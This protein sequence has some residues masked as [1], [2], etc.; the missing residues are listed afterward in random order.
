MK[1][2][3]R[4]AKAELAILF[5][6]P[7]AWLILVIFVFQV[8]MS[9]CGLFENEVR[10]Q[11]LGYYLYETTRNLFSGSS[12]VFTSV[13]HYLY[14]YLPLLTM[15]LMSREMSSGSIK[16]LYSSPVTNTQIILGKYLSMMIYG[17]ILLS[18]LL[19]FILFG[20][21]VVKDFN[22][23]VPLSGFLGVYLLLCAYAAI[24]LFMSGLTSYQVIAAVGTL[25]VLAVLN[26]VGT[27]G[28]SV[29]LI[30]DIT[31]WLSISGRS[32]SL[33]DGLICSEDVLYFGIVVLLFLS[34]SI[35]RLQSERE[36]R[37]KILMASRYGG[38]IFCALLLGYVSSRPACMFYYDVTTAKSNTLTVQ[39]QEVMEKMEGGLKIVSYVNLLDV[40]CWRGLPANRNMDLEQFKQYV[41]FKPEIEME[42][43]YYYDK[44]N[45]PELD[46]RYPELS[47]RDRASRQAEIMRLDFEKFLSP[48]QVRE[49]VDLQPE[50]NRFVRV[51]ER[52]NGRK[53]FL[54]LYN[55]NRKDPLET[56]ITTALKRLVTDVPQVAFLS[57]HGERDIFRKGERDYSLMSTDVNSRS[58]LV[59][60]GFDVFELSLA[61][62]DVPAEV[63]ILVIAELREELSVPEAEKITRYIERGGNLIVLGEPERQ[64][65]MNPLIKQLGVEFMPGVLVQTHEGLAPDLIVA[66]VT[67]AAAKFSSAYAGLLA[68]QYHVVMPGA[69]GLDFDTTAGFEVTPIFSIGEDGAWS[70][71]E[72]TVFTD[73]QPVLNPAAGE[74][75]GDIPT[76]LALSRKLGEKEQRIMIIGD[77]DCWSN[78]E[79]TAGRESVRQYN[80]SLIRES[81]H[82]LSEG[83]F[84]MGLSRPGSPDNVVYFQL[85]RV[86]WVQ[87]VFMGLIPLLILLAGITL[88]VKRR[89]K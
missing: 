4:I 15:G 43:V 52:E 67:L 37:S 44:T 18:V 29:D 20:L 66:G 26:I 62:G 58:A 19:L 9:F 79:L 69:V 11:T 75:E 49:R 53:T 82:W 85:G 89:R 81:F 54:R 74:K 8:G 73:N 60:T 40:E 88:W 61:E 64:G 21:M 68:G 10:E 41:R 87:V 86:I 46:S 23:Q 32:N 65:A 55:D 12:G 27:I 83:E 57:G 59:N 14:L 72:M 63:D 45:S 56:E 48:E 77:A 3:F 71:L 17:F 39:S 28:Q 80:Y 22:W 36:K 24:G 5:Y 70:E 33:V 34:L 76:A 16:L 38:V 1:T 42:Y 13:S 78:R 6:S 25:V 51:L 7:I 35:L 84:P 50:H 2:I 31:Y 30:R 47:D